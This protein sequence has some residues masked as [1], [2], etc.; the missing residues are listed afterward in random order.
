MW[1][2]ANRPTVLGILLAAAISCLATETA[3]AEDRDAILEKLEKPISLEK[4]IPAG[5]TIE[6]A[7]EDL[8]EKYTLRFR[9]DMRTFETLRQYD[10]KTWPVRMPRVYGM[11]LRTILRLLLDQAEARYV[12]TQNAIVICPRGKEKVQV[13]PPDPIM[14]RRIA[15]VREKL[16]KP[17]TLDKG[18]DPKTPLQD[19]VE[20]LQDR[21]DLT[22]LI[23]PKYQQLSKRFVQLAPT[24]GARLEDVL[25]TL[26][27][28]VEAHYELWDAAIV[29]LP[30]KK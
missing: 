26:L 18:I 30:G 14:V 20:F 28:Q 21:Y 29:I 25:H 27:A 4:G 6:K 1:R 7:L 11:N 9:F 17:V 24:V 19:A 3:P 2:I 16:A 22:M 8:G 12:V 5:T 23:H 15:D 13:P 10:V